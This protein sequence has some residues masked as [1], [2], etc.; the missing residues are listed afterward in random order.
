MSDY[1][2]NQ[3]RKFEDSAENYRK[4]GNEVFRELVRQL[5]LVATVFLSISAFTLNSEKI[6]MKLYVFEKYS[7]VFAWITFGLSIVSGIG[8]FFVDYKYFGKWITAKS[9]IVENLYHGKISEKDLPKLIQE[10]QKDIPSESSTCFVYLQSFF[11]VFGVISLI[12][13]MVKIL[14]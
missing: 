13:T 11:L 2:I 3:Q 5:I 7:L 10:K 9:S 14:F 4:E 12:F 8:Q 6:V 1:L